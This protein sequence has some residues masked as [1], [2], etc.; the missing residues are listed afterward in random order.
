MDFQSHNVY[1]NE[2][3]SKIANLSNQMVISDDI[4][5]S[6]YTLTTC[7]SFNSCLLPNK[8]CNDN[9][10][11]LHY[12][13]ETLQSKHRLLYKNIANKF[14]LLQLINFTSDYMHWRAM[15]WNDTFSGFILDEVLYL[16][17]IH[18]SQNYVL[19]CSTDILRKSEL[20]SVDCIRKDINSFLN[21][22]PGEII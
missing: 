3:Y 17:Y 18:H 7:D 13:N 12:V 6:Y 20:N 16:F 14:T 9:M 4:A 2:S 15:S 11:V 19:V 1:K 8:S 10:C 5:H 22:Y 21:I